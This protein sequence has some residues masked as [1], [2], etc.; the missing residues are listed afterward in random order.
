LYGKSFLSDS[1]PFPRPAPGTQPVGRARAAPLVLL[2]QKDF[3]RVWLAGALGGFMRWMDVLV[4][5]VY[6]LQITGSAFY[7]AL[8]LFVRIIPMFLFGAA[9][10]ALAEMVDRKKLLVAAMFL[11]SAVYGILAWL[12]WSG[13]LQIWQL[14]ILVIF[15]GLYWTLELPIRRTMIAE[16]AGL[17]RL[18]ATMGLESS[19]TNLTRMLGP[20]AGGFLFELAGL[21]GTLVVGTLIYVI[22]AFAMMPVVYARA[23]Q[24]GARPS[25]FAN[26][27]KGLEYA[28][29]SRSIRAT[30][31]ITI[32]LNLFGFSFVSMVPVIAKNVLGLSPG[33]TGILMAAEG[34]GA[35]AGALLI[36]FYAKPARFRQIYFGGSLLYIACI[37][38]FALSSLF[39]LSMT[40]LWI[41]GFGVSGFASMQSALMIT[42][43]PPEMRNRIM[44]LLIMCIGVG[45]LGILIV[46]SLSE[47]LG[48]PTGILITASTGMIGLLCAMVL[49]PEMRKQ[50]TV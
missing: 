24:A 33:P 31:A 50:G 41:G 38:L 44:G 34:F 14:A 4:V 12:A 46:G 1:D 36:T 39:E 5:G 19:T 47:I 37:W 7:V 16:I 45:P 29:T 3:R 6:V 21:P 20:F 49:W 15:S 28:R 2:G 42:S 48:A 18:G 27:L 8:T 25:F 11:L 26:I 35:F 22:A 17:E 43:A 40:L 10:G 32:V 13:L 30:L 23:P 9:A